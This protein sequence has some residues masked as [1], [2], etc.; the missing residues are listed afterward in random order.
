MDTFDVKSLLRVALVAGLFVSATA[1]MAAASAGTFSDEGGLWGSDVRAGF[2]GD[3]AEAGALASAAEL[4]EERAAT[5]AAEG[6]VRVIGASLT[7]GA[8]RCAGGRCREAGG[9]PAGAAGRAR[10]GVARA[11]PTGALRLVPA[12]LRQ[13]ECPGSGRHG[14]SSPRARRDVGDEE[15]E[16]PPGY[17]SIGRYLTDADERPDE[18]RDLA[19][20]FGAPSN[21][22][23]D[24]DGASLLAWDVRER[25]PRGSYLYVLE[26]DGEGRLAQVHRYFC[27]ERRLDVL[28]ETCVPIASVY[29]DSG[30]PIAVGYTREGG[31]R[32]RQ[33]DDLDP[34]LF[35]R[36]RDYTEAD[37][38]LLYLQEY[39][40]SLR[41]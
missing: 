24:A 31:P 28:A 6:G 18:V 2:E 9:G 14:R 39:F 38:L 23:A 40:D 17:A 19:E 32:E 37:E 15:P 36:A 26:Q 7:G 10:D 16:E 33:A 5:G 25:E 35:S 1:V 20:I 34:S 22:V 27:P 30:A 12:W 4:G 21:V 3:E 29:S 13:G 11:S 41:G 8:A